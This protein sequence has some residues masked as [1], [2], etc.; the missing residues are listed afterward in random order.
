[1]IQRSL[2]GARSATSKQSNQAKND[3]TKPV[4]VQRFGERELGLMVEMGAG[5]RE[6]P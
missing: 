1:M 3:L 2:N 5:A 6:A 4:D